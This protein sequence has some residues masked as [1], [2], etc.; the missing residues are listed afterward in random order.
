MEL[1]PRTSDGGISISWSLRMPEEEMPATDMSLSKST[2]HARL[3]VRESDLALRTWKVSSV[4]FDTLPGLVF[5][6]PSPENDDCDNAF[7]SR[8]EM[9]SPLRASKIE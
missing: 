7:W 4:S 5:R 1:G 2:K 6:E 3:T 9:H 8:K